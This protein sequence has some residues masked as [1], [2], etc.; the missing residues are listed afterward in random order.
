[1]KKQNPVVHFEIPANDRKRS[2]DFYSKVFGW[3]MNQLGG[4]MND[5]VVVMTDKSDKNGPLEKG[6]INGGIYTKTPEMPPQY[7]S[8]VIA[9]EDIDAKIKEVEAAGGKIVG[10][11]YEIPGVGIY[12]SFEDTEGNKLSILQPKGM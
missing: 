5:Y 1:M 12:V 2:V 7:P 8:F 11:P 9:V 10:K 4:E 6:R 3:E